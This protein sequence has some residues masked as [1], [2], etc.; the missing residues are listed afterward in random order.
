MK[1]L[2]W[3]GVAMLLMSTVVFADVDCS[4][5]NLCKYTRPDCENLECP[6]IIVD[7]D[8]AGTS[9]VDVSLYRLP[10]C[11]GDAVGEDG[12]DVEF[13]KAGTYILFT[14]FD[15]C[16]LPL[17][18]YSVNWTADKCN[19]GCGDLDLCGTF[20]L[21]PDCDDLADGLPAMSLSF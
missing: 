16:A 15:L 19:F 1:I 12:A 13:P 7:V 5:A 6:A 14:R 18:P 4:N 11:L 3:V 20:L 2:K 9:A 10:E 8:D 21:T 17:L